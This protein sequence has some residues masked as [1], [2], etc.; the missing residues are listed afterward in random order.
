MTSCASRL[1]I[2]NQ[3]VRGALAAAA[4]GKRKRDEPL[5]PQYVGCLEKLDERRGCDGIVAV[6]RHVGRLFAVSTSRA[7]ETVRF[8]ALCASEATPQ[9]E[10]A[11]S[12]QVLPSMIPLELWPVIERRHEPAVARALELNGFS[13]RDETDES[14]DIRVQLTHVP[15]RESTP[16]APLS[17]LIDLV[18]QIN[19]GAVVP[20]SDASLR[21]FRAMVRNEAAAA[22]AT[23][24][25]R[26]DVVLALLAQRSDC[27]LVANKCPHGE[28]LSIEI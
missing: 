7:R 12:I 15:A 6:V 9:V 10:L 19:D 16:V 2:H 13:L 14:G 11:C 23:S 28:T 21:S 26:S 4:A 20:R 3:F 24:N 8:D 25:D 17:A 1:G 18:R 22:A 27:L 5:A